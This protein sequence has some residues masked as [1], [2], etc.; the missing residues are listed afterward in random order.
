[1][2]CGSVAA[3]GQKQ[4]VAGLFTGQALRWCLWATGV[5]W[6]S[7]RVGGL[8]LRCPPVHGPGAASPGK[9]PQTALYNTELVC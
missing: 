8:C 4:R 2:E 9:V 3:A 5:A 7:A 6:V 1:M